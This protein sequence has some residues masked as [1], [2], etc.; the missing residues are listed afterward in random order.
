MEFAPVMITFCILASVGASVFTVGACM[1]SSRISQNQGVEEN[2]PY[3]D[4]PDPEP[5]R[6]PAP[7]TYSY[8]D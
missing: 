2:Y 8:N 4:L 5:S 3:V 6:Q 1:L 7:D